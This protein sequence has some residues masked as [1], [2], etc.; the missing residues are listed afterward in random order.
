M[1]DDLDFIRALQ[2]S[3][4]DDAPRLVFA[5]WLD[6]RGDPRGPLLRLEVARHRPRPD[7]GNLGEQLLQARAGLDPRWLALVDRPQPGW[8]IARTRPSPTTYGKAV[9]AFIH[10]DHYFF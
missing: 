10:N 2:A 1:S 6:E 8:R 9:P 5:D 3:P 7:A 4:D